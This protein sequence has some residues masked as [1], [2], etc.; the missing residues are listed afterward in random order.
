LGS[1]PPSHPK[2][3]RAREKIQVYRGKKHGRAIKFGANYGAITV[4]LGTHERCAGAGKEGDHRIDIGWAGPFM[5]W[6]IDAE[7]GGAKEAPL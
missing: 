3:A 5:K 7:F 1:Y 2:W 4:Q 6:V